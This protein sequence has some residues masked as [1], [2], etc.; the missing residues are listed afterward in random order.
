MPNTIGRGPAF[1][2]RF[3]YQDPRQGGA[4]SKIQDAKNKI[5]GEP[6]EVASLILFNGP[7]TLDAPIS[8]APSD[9]K[10]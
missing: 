5:D 7:W 2:S 10:I 8:A 3:S 1:S 4:A 6:T 9:L